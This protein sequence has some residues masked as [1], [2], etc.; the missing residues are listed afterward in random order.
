MR[1]QLFPLLAGFLLAGCAGGRVYDNN[2]RHVCLCAVKAVRAHGYVVKEQDFKPSEGTLVAAFSVPDLLGT[3]MS[4]SMVKRA[5]AFVW[6]AWEHTKLDAGRGKGKRMRI[7]ERV[8]AKFRASGGGLFSWIDWNSPNH[9]TVDLTADVTD[10]GKGD[11]VINR[12]D[13]PKDYRESLFT[14]LSDC[15]AGKQV[16]AMAPPKRAEPMVVVPEPVVA[17]TQVLPVTGGMSSTPVLP[18]G[19]PGKLEEVE[20]REM[21]VSA[22]GL[23]DSGNYQ[24]AI[25]NLER[26]AKAD[27]QNAEALGYLGASYHQLGRNADAIRV[28]E[29]YLL[30]V[31][32]DYRTRE[33]VGELKGK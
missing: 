16:V 24:G 7:E 29:Q 18:A 15:L 2:I 27:P 31:P 12:E 17:K 20:A 11:W 14:A 25:T 6:N 13:R 1:G 28:Y 23:Y 22:R 3:E 30:L 5:G 9:T 10:Y 33:F 19:E 21:L 32:G 26:V 4:G 8:V